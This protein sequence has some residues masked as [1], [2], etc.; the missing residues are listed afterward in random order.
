MDMVPIVFNIGV[1]TSS[2]PV[3]KLILDALNATV[4]F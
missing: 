4:V 1:V 2:K 3:S